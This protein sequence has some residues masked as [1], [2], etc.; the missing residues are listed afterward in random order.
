MPNYTFTARDTTGRWHKGTQVADN[1]SALAGNMRTRGWAL[2]SAKAVEV[3]SNEPAAR[4]RGILPATELD[5]EMGLRML[6]NMLDGGL[7]LMSALKTCADQAR[8]AR[9]GNVWIEIHDRI[10]GGMPLAEA[11]ARHPHLFA[12]LVVQL[13]RAGELSGN[14]EMVL[15]R[16]AEQLEVR[17]NLFVTLLSGLMYPAIT[18]LVA[19]SVTAFLV[20]KIIPEIS[21]FLAGQEKRLPP[22][23]AALIKVSNFLNSYLLFI[24]ILLGAIVVALFLIRKW[25]QGALVMDRII[26]R[27]PLFGKI[28]RLAGT[29]MFAR[30]LGMLLDAGVPMLAA[31]ETAGNLMKN[32][33]IAQRVELSRQSV[34]KG[35]QLARTLGAGREFMPMLPRMVAVGEETG[36]L[37]DVLIKVA[38]FHE[39]QLESLIKRMMVLIEPIMTII[40]GV[41]VGFVYLAFFMAVYTAATG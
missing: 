17:R 33:A 39:K 27:I 35:N 30:G 20:I 25:P 1:S 36:T 19:V 6:A 34:L 40:V 5:V 29:A 32:H 8:R 41:I 2:V 11:M 13:V 12:K 16:A 15:D 14:L 37:S 28:F 21:Q 24:G 7:T 31:L 18:I 38:N 26:L 3:E 23:T 4:P 10:A 9:M 22:V